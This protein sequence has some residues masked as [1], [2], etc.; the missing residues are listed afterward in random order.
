MSET[1]IKGFQLDASITDLNDV[2]STGSPVIADTD[3]LL[4]NSASG[5]WE[6]TP[7]TLANSYFVNITTGVGSPLD[8]SVTSLP[9]GWSASYLGVGYF[10]ITH[11]LGSTE[12]G[13]ALSAQFNGGSRIMNYDV[14]N[15]NYVEFKIEDDTGAAV[16]GTV[17]G[18]LFFAL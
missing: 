12:P 3:I 17:A 13:M 18:M 1:K 2:V 9:A 15:A 11:N 16:E 10:R 5:T 4:F 14:I 6:N 7:Q 8:V